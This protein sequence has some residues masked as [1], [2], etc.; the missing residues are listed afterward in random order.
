MIVK[1]YPGDILELKKPHP[2]GGKRFQVVFSG[3]DVKITC[4]TCRHEMVIS[5]VKL[6]K[7]IR[8]ILPGDTHD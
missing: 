7:S 8:K 5:R 3:S 2:C 1:F 6:E 4:L